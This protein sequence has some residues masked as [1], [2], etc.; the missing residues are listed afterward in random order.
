MAEALPASYVPVDTSRPRTPARAP[1]AWLGTVIIAACGVFLLGPLVNLLIWAFSQSWFFPASL[2]T[3]WTFKWFGYVL[4][5]A[6]LTSAIVYSITLAPTVTIVSAL[7]CWPAAY[8]IGRS[9]FPGRRFVTVFILAANAF[10]TFGIYISLAT[11]M[12][13]LNLIATFPGVVIVQLLGT[14]VTMTWIPAAAF[15][16]V[17]R[18][19]EEASLDAGASRFKTFLR[20]TLPLAMPGLITAAVLA[21]LAAFDESQGTLLI[22]VPNIVTM[23]VMMY[24]LVTGY[25]EPVAAVFSILLAIPSLILLL[26][27]RRH[28]V[29][30]ALASG[31]TII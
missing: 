25:S 2:P 29:Q 22:G 31:F 7:I 26:L 30:G 24:S 18:T 1:M 16:A 3:V 9:N 11:L 8:A 15:A 27:I 28:L 19:L 14:L 5:Q 12:Y 23:P 17:P 10:P 20:V 21:F 4:S 13:A 6:H